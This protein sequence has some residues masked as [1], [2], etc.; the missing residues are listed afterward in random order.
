M[1][2]MKLRA[3]EAAKIQ[4]ARQFFSEISRSVESNSVK[5]DVV[6][7]YSSLMDLVSPRA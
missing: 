4:C 7:S 5:Y 1:S 3:I 6:D 2:S